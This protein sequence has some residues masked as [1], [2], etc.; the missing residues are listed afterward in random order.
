MLKNLVARYISYRSE[1]KVYLGLVFHV[2]SFVFVNSVMLSIYIERV[3]FKEIQHLQIV[4]MIGI[5]GDVSLDCHD[6]M[7]NIYV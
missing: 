2:R 5:F 6:I 1:A 7:R 4:Q 3:I